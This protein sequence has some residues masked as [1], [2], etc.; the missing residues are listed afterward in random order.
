[1][2]TV[3]IFPFSGELDWTESSIFWFGVDEQG[4]PGYNYSDVRVTY[5]SDALHF[6]A[7]VVDYYLWYDEDAG[8]E[9]DLSQYD[10]LAVYLDTAHDGAGSPQS[11]DYYFLLGARHWQ[12]M[13]NYQRQGQGTGTAWNSDWSPP[14]GWEA[15]STISWNIV[16]GPNDNTGDLDF[17]WDAQLTLPWSALGLSGPPADGTAWGLG[18]QL[19]DRD[20]DTPSGLLT[21]ETWPE[22]FDDEAPSTWGKLV[23]NPPPRQASQT[24]VQGSVVIQR[25]LLGS[26]QDAWMGGGGT[27]SGGQFGGGVVN[28]GHSGDLFTG[29]ETA[30][31]HFPCFNKSF[32]RFGLDEIPAGQSIVSAELT[33]HLY[34]NADPNQALPSWVHLYTISDPWEEMTIHWNNAPLA[35]E[36][37]AATWVNPYSSPGDIQWPGDP[38][39]WD[40]TQAVAQAYAAG[41]PLSIALYAS[42]KDQHSSKYYVGSES[43][44]TAGRPLLTVTWGQPATSLDKQASPSVAR[45]GESVDF[46]LTFAGTGEALSLVDQLPAGLSYLGPVNA[47]VGSASYDSPTHQIQWSGTPD[48]GQVVN[49]TYT[50][51]VATHDNRVLVNT[52]RL[53]ADGASVSLADASVLVNPY[54]LYLPVVLRR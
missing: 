41:Q 9:D 22:T 21:P 51:Q 39:T 48:P 46:G 38:Y 29:S 17:G 11:D 13:S 12:D 4:L 32:L 40:V 23:F 33:L 37:V 47:N 16:G 19:Y 34:G 27:C 28:H 3:N 1:V 31:T 42:D 43:S 24:A 26:V 14:G 54:S 30:A 35:Q 45:F 50:T 10:A 2:R 8:P 52:V 25:D 5:S 7:N 53:S 6:R 44:I 36:N 20:A 15:F 49:V 18:V